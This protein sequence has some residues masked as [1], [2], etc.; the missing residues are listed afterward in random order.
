MSRVTSLIPRLGR[1][2]HPWFDEA[3]F[4]VWSVR[5]A[6]ITLGGK[7]RKKSGHEGETLPPRLHR[8][9]PTP[10][11]PG[12]CPPGCWTG[13]WNCTASAAISDS[14]SSSMRPVPWS[15]RRCEAASAP[16]AGHNSTNGSARGSPAPP[17]P[18]NDDD[19][20]ILCPPSCEA[21][22]LPRVRRARA[23]PRRDPPP[24]A[25]SPTPPTRGIN[26]HRRHD[27]TVRK[28]D[29]GAGEL[30]L[31]VMAGEPAAA[32]AG[33]AM[34]RRGERDAEEW[35]WDNQGAACGR[36]RSAQVRRPRGQHQTSHPSHQNTT[37]I[38]TFSTG[39]MRN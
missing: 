32:A 7:K 12:R 30:R 26:P 16:V 15:T 8:N 5:V 4:A 37:R 18:N 3:D 25:A 35:S 33:V 10:H 22:A 36:R 6:R 14:G 28:T 31:L 39:W 38:R 27:A 11:L 19:A 29:R 23:K 1:Q 21:E 24:T 17:A 9:H 20:K 34:H 13:G 2:T